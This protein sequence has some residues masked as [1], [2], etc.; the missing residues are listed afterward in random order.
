MLT[1]AS[2]TVIFLCCSFKTL[3]SVFETRVKNQGKVD[4]FGQ[5]IGGVNRMLV[6]F[7]TGD[8]KNYLGFGNGKVINYL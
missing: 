5:E 1:N 2:I 3:C 7:I 4:T 8:E 6:Q